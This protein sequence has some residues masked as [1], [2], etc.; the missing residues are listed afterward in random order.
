[1]VD[2]H[3]HVEKKHL[4]LFGGLFLL[5]VGMGFLYSFGGDSPPYMGHSSGEIR[6]DPNTVNISAIDFENPDDMVPV[7]VVEGLQREVVG[8]CGGGTYMIGVSE[9]GSVICG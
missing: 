1:M 9:D 7:S 6:F 4:Y 2:I 5:L 3:I 8:N